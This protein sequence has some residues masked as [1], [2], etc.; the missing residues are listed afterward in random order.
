[1]ANKKTIRDYLNEIKAQYSL[2][3]EHKGFIDSR[4]AALDKKTTERKPTATQVASEK[5][6]TAVHAELLADGRKLR[7]SEMMKVLPSFKEY[8]DLSQSKANAIVK[9][10]K[11]TGRVVKTEEKGVAYFTAVEV[12]GI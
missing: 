1:M 5:L 11:D 2:T 12:E 6:A 7:V 10:L 3:E 8:A 9:K 4:L